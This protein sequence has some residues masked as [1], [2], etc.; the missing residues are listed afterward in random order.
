MFGLACLALVLPLTAAFPQSRPEEQTA[1]FKADLRVD[2]NRDGTVDLSGNT[3]SNGKNTWSE[4]S[5][6]LFLPNIGV[7][8]RHCGSDYTC[9]DAYT[10]TPWA[11]EYMAP[12]RTV[13]MPNISDSATATVSISDPVAR[14]NVRIFLDY[15]GRIEELNFQD[16]IDIKPLPPPENDR[17]VYLE[18]DTPIPADKLRQGLTLGIDSRDTRRPGR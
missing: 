8:R 14:K 2:T 4:T 9:H 18:N 6:A 15:P 10:N 13:P 1:P 5:G 7:A 12:M 17:W 3:D 11:P 16:L